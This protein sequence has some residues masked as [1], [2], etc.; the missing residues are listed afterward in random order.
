MLHDSQQHPICSRASFVRLIALR[1]ASL[2]RQTLPRIHQALTCNNTPRI[3][4]NALPEAARQACPMR[5]VRE[6]RQKISSALD[7]KLRCALMQRLH[8]TLELH[9]ATRAARVR[10]SERQG[11]PRTQAGVQWNETLCLKI[12]HKRST[13]AQ[14]CKLHNCC[15]SC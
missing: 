3:M 1:P 5:S 13:H 2:L 12:S 11:L 15:V 7:V 9:A 14:Q 4:A 8:A 10:M 6:S